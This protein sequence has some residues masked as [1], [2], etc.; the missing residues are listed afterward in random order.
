MIN[1]FLW[2]DSDAG[3]V[4]SWIPDACVE[5]VTSVY[6]FD[7]QEFG[8][9]RGYK[10]QI[11]HWVR[12]DTEFRDGTSDAE[13]ERIAKLYSEAAGREPHKVTRPERITGAEPLGTFE[14]WEEAFS[15]FKQPEGVA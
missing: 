6:L 12:T 3:G 14:S 8:F 9:A 2:R 15:K 10:E 5:S 7:P 1:A 11:I 13:R 4:G